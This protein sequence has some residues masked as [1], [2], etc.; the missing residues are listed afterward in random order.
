MLILILLSLFVSF[1]Q[2]QA[3]AKQIKET[4]DKKCGNSWHCVVGETFALEVS[5]ET[6]NIIYMFL[7]SN[8]GVCAWKCS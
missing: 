6:K 4:L 1:Q 7:N 5:Y 8:L 3:A 2:L